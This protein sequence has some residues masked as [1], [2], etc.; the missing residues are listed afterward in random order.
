MHVRLA[1]PILALALLLV[2]APAADAKRGPCVLGQ[3]QPKCHIIPAKVGPVHDGD[4]FKAKFKSSGGLRL[5]RM[6]GIQAMELHKYGRRGGRKGECNGIEAVETLEKMIRNS[7]VRLVTQDLK[8]VSEGKR[9]RLRRTVHVKQGGRWIDPGEELLKKGLVLW[10]PNAKEWAWNK[11]YRVLAAQAARKEIGLW[12]STSCGSGPAQDIPLRM[13]LKWDAEDADAKNVNGEFA[14]IRN[15]DPRRDLSLAGWWFRDSDLRRYT[16]KR[17][18]VIPAGGAIRVLPGR[19]RDTADTFHWGLG[20]SIWENVIGGAHAQGDGAYLFDPDGDLRAYVQYPCV[21][22]CR[23]PA[24]G[25]VSINATARGTELI[26]LRNTSSTPLDLT[27]YE[28]ESVPWF[29]EF[30]P[31]T[32]LDPGQVLILYI[33]NGPGRRGAIVK[34]WGFNKSLLADRKDAVTLRNPLGAPVVC[35]SWGG[36]RCPNV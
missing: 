22:S 4:T 9:G 11:K 7:K 29:F 13:K 14:R 28:I 23:D 15:L 27:E 20:G 25:R 36:V 19:G 30:S 33:Q 21:I 16:F 8:S 31:G 12:D 6:N 17:G 26:T 5:V 24:A 32:I 1:L 10:F 3:K 18:D 2:A 34:E 35:D